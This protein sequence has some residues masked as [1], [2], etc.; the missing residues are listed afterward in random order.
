MLDSEKIE[1]IREM[2]KDFW[3]TGNVS[4]DSA[5]SL[6]NAIDVVVDFK[7]KD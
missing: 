5:V 7:R 1:L 3:E 2:I 4:E 6:L